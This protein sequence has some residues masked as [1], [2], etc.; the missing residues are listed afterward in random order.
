MLA[1]SLRHNGDTRSCYIAW[2]VWTKQFKLKAG[3]RR[4]DATWQWSFVAKC[5]IQIL[6]IRASDC[7]NITELP[8]CILYC[9][10]IQNLCANMMHENRMQQMCLFFKFSLSKDFQCK[11]F[12]ILLLVLC[13]FEV[14]LF[15]TEIRVLHIK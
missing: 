8:K 6:K 4:E 3:E 15:K 5:N 9:V 13:I 2:K 11:G 14:H 7:A 10:S 1:R 12:L